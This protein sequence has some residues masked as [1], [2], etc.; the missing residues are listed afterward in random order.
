MKV[1]LKLSVLAILIIIYAKYGD[2]TNIPRVDEFFRMFE[3]D[4]WSN[5]VA[6]LGA[7]LV[8]LG[9]GFALFWDDIKRH[10]L[11]RYIVP[12]FVVT[13]FVIY[14]FFGVTWV[15]YV[16][17]ERQKGTFY[18]YNKADTT[19]KLILKYQ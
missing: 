11:V 14:H 2:Y 4:T 8:V 7:E 10:R 13:V 18:F 9:V 3:G 6:L 15:K 16:P 12:T 5:F 17:K 1:V 19:Q